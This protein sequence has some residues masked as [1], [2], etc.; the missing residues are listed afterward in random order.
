MKTQP[1][2]IVILDSSIKTFKPEI[3]NFVLQQAVPALEKN[4]GPDMKFYVS[5]EILPIIRK[6][7][8]MYPYRGSTDLSIEASKKGFAGFIKHLFNPQSVPTHFERPDRSKMRTLTG[9]V[10]ELTNPGRFKYTVEEVLA[11][12]RK[13]IAKI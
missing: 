11:T 1:C 5:R 12:A 4:F 8:P 13:A 9:A 2:A 6:L 7:Q 10:K 3:R